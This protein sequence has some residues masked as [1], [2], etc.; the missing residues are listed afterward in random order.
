MAG[1]RAISIAVAAVRSFVTCL[2]CCF[3]GVHQVVCPTVLPIVRAAPPGGPLVVFPNSPHRR[4]RWPHTAV[5]CLA[6]PVRDLRG[7]ASLCGEEARESVQ[8]I[9]VRDLAGIAAGRHNPSPK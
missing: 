5:H 1:G 7:S 6:V 8:R 3:I 9:C 2:M 4:N